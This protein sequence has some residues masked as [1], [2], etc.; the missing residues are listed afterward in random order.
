M[1]NQRRLLG[2][3]LCRGL[4]AFAVILVHSGDRSWGIP[5]SDSAIQLRHSFYFAVPFFLATSLYFT[6]QKNLSNFT[7]YF[8]QKRLKRIIVPYLLWSIFYLISKS[9]VFWFSNDNSQISKLFSDPLSIIFFGGASYHLYFLPLLL[10]GTVWLYLVKYIK[11]MSILSLVLW[12]IFS[13]SIY[14]ALFLTDNSFEMDSYIAFSDIIHLIPSGNWFYPIWRII[15]VYFAWSLR[16]LPYFLGAI[17]INRLL[18][19]Y[20]NKWLYSKQIII[21]LAFIFYF[22]NTIG[23]RIALIPLT[24]NDLVIA[25]CLLLLGIFCSKYIKNNILIRNVGLC[26]FGIYLIHP[27]VKSAVEI[28][29]NQFLPQF[30]NSVSIASMLVYSISTFLI[31]WISIFILSKHKLFSKLI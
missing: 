12:L 2:I 8:W 30:T 23:K 22:M 17:L 19:N 5:I 21:S 15:L 13:I 25:Y 20:Q 7:L 14:Q 24:L 3:D 29:L 11:K 16:C 28:V 9:I 10:S 1:K 6:T 4:A 26:S 27:F 18:E 31:S